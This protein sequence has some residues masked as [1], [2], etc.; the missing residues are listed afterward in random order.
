[1]AALK[2]DPSSEAPQSPLTLLKTLQT[3]AIEPATKTREITGFSL[4]DGTPLPLEPSS[5]PAPSLPK[6]RELETTLVTP[7][8]QPSDEITEVFATL[9]TTQR[10][11]TRTAIIRRRPPIPRDEAPTGNEVT[12]TAIVQRKRG[13]R[14]L[15]TLD[16]ETQTDLI[17]R[18]PRNKS[19]D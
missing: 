13:Q 15:A 2:L 4:R 5:F 7:S 17:E 8:P 1:M 18:V 12:H 14:V 9:S 3:Q 6:E 10:E 11:V 16:D 19:D